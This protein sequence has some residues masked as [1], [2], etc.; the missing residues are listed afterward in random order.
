[1]GPA[2]G[3]VLIVCPVT[4]INVG[5]SVAKPETLV[6][7][8]TLVLELEKRVPQVVGFLFVIFDHERWIMSRL[9][10]DRVGVLT[11]DKGKPAIRQFT[12][13]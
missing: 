9:G 10:R 3:K 11:G 12:N 6:Y 8:K 4:L 13:S 7:A 2:V 5:N 1:M